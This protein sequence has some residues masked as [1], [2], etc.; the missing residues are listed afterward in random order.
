[1][2][3]LRRFTRADIL[4]TAAIERSNLT[5]YIRALVDCGFVAIEQNRNGMAGS[6]DVLRIARDNGP[7]AP[8]MHRDGSMT[9]PNTGDCW[10][11]PPDDAE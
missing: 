6:R 1:M 2:R 7:Q 11:V 8:V 5:K 3:I 10:Y 4:T 9:D